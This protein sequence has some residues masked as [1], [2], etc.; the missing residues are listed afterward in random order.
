V[1]WV[2]WM[3]SQVLAS[4]DRRIATNAYI[5]AGF[6]ICILMFCVKRLHRYYRNRDHTVLRVIKNCNFCK[7]ICVIH[8]STRPLIIFLLW[9][10][11]FVIVSW[12]HIRKLLFVHEWGY[13]V[14]GML[15]DRILWLVS[16]WS[17]ALYHHIWRAFIYLAIVWTF[18][19]VY[20]RFS[21]LLKLK[22]VKFLFWVRSKLGWV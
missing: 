19:N 6:I 12:V 17:I 21:R 20:R 15:T 22:S 8:W 3:I 14:S 9:A 13:I 7:I 4:E 11:R 2:E 16:F 5:R 1:L 10:T 18:I